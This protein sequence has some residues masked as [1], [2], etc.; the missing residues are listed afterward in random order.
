MGLAAAAALAALSLAVA[1]CGDDEKGPVSR[2]TGAATTT[3]S[4]PGSPAAP[5]KTAPEPEAPETEHQQSAPHEPQPEPGGGSGASPEDEEGG[6]GDEIPA[7][8][9]ALFTGRGGRIRP[10]LVRVPPFIAIR[11][12]LRSADGAS[13]ALSGPGGR[14]AARAQGP[15]GTAVFD[16]LRPGRRLVLRGSSSSVTIEASAEPGP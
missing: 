7:S 16:G 8:A 5:S 10:R 4:T 1:A 12:V 9:Q 15:G 6:A 13:Y 14:V 3:S 2:D 11:V